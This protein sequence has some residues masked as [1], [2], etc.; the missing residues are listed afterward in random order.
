MSSAPR[1]GG[2]IG[3]FLLL[4]LLVCG[5]LFQQ[6]ITDQF[7]FWS[8]QP[9]GEIA[10]LAQR[11]G[12]SDKGTFYFYVTHPRLE[13]AEEFNNDCHRDEPASPILGCYI[14]GVDTIHIYDITKEKL[15]GIKE[16]TAA[17]EMLHAVWARLSASE[18]GSLA[19]PL[20][21]AYDRLKTP[22]LERRMEYYGR[23]GEDSQISELYAI[24]PTEFS[25]IGSELEDHFGAY[26]D[27]RQKVVSLHA[28]YRQT[29]EKLENEMMTLSEGL[30]SKRQYIEQEERALSL[31]VS[32]LNRRVENFNAR[33]ARGDFTS[34]Q[35][36]NLER[37]RLEVERR[38]SI[39]RG[40]AIDRAIADYNNDVERLNQ[41]GQRHDQLTKS[42]DS[43]QELGQ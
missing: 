4:G 32:S 10:S 11:S 18:R 3:S 38:A 30:E 16:V 36:F 7:K 2:W 43:I 13:S 1:R 37:S 24:L 31:A 41:L 19:T 23:N 42:I 15:D 39:G 27:D 12:M 28:S 34:Q 33:A 5:V 17:H 14:S 20:K 6:Q 22:E 29:F 8:Y 21:A 9:S 35:A 40:E 26:F 25:D